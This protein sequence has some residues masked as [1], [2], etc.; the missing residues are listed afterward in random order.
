M[1]NKI[2]PA[3]GVVS[4]T[5]TVS[6][7]NLVTMQNYIY[8]NFSDAVSAAGGRF[9]LYFCQNCGLV[10]NAAFDRDLVTYDE[11]Y[12]AYIPSTAFENYYR[13]I[14]GFLH[15]RFD[16]YRGPVVDIACGKGNFLNL[17][18]EMYPDVK[19]LG[20][21]P[22]YE[23]EPP[24]KNIEFVV[25]V[26]K[27]QHIT[28]APSLV[29]CR[30]AFDQIEHPM[31]FLRSIRL[32]LSNYKDT[33]FF[34]EVGDLKWMLTNRSF[35]DLCY[36]RCSFFTAESLGNILK[37]A[38]FTV[39]KIERSFG[40]QYLRAYGV[41]RQADAAISASGLD[42]QD[43]DW[44]GP[45]LAA[46]ASAEKRLIR[47]MTARLRELKDQGYLIA[48]WGIATKGVV[49]CNLVD[50]HNTLFDYCIDINSQKLDCFVPHSGHR[51]AG[52]EVLKEAGSSKAVIVVMN[53]NY[54]D[55]IKS[56]CSDL[57]LNT[58]FLDASGQGLVNKS[59]KELYE[60]IY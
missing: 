55:E 46:Y 15:E 52:P 14:A 22:S 30:H 24:R 18:C 58:L 23:S 31:E 40:Q 48:V 25:D 36:E 42:F 59:K 45:Q 38:N 17:L 29:L 7:A 9:E 34:I 43:T 50:P 21:D 32:S 53:P 60:G 44:T 33:P 26:F 10:F 37:L 56:Y 13:E 12:T 39:H 27:E 3:C 57:N 2:C 19:G 5:P 6:R 51:I 11:D 20:I 8:R 49:F 4:E 47:E 35:A 41:V 1:L 16:L 54:L 28:T